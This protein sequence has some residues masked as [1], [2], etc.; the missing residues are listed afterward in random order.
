M[1]AIPGFRVTALCDL[2]QDA[3]D[4]ALGIVEHAEGIA[5]FRSYDDFVQFDG[6]AHGPPWMPVATGGYRRGRGGA[7]GALDR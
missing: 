1:Q 7:G 3:I 4:N 2:Y 5:C 6:M